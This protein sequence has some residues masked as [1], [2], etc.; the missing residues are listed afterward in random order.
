M[1]AAVM[2]V[3]VVVVVVVAVVVVVTTIIFPMHSCY[4]SYNSHNNQHSFTSCMNYSVV[5][6]LL[7]PWAGS[8]KNHGP[9]PSRGKRF[10]SSP[11]H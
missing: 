8:L 2:V 4:V 1:A 7:H 3:V 5:G 6:T 10:F 9:I 11:K